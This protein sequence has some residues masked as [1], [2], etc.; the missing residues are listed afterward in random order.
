MAARAVSAARMI[1]LDICGVDVVAES[2]QYPLEDQHGG[3]VEVNAAPGLRMHL[4][5]SFGKGR[6]VGEAIIANIPPRC[7]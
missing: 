5:P 3:V 6:A 2:V 1:G 7:A 4:N